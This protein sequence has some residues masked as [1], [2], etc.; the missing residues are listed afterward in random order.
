MVASMLFLYAELASNFIFPSVCSLIYGCKNLYY[1]IHIISRPVFSAA[2]IISDIF[3]NLQSL[4]I[5]GPAS[6][7]SLAIL[8]N[9]YF[10][11]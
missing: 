1:C 6:S 5:Y 10:S 3:L 2:P 7:F 8:V 11:Q 9:F 4:G